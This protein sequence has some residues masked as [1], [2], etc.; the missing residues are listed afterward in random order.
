MINKGHGRRKRSNGCIIKFSKNPNSHI[1]LYYYNA[2]C[3]NCSLIIVYDYSSNV[4]FT[5]W[6]GVCSILR[7]VEILFEKNNK[8]TLKNNI[9]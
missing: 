8:Y 3:H 2:K 7:V 9:K 6:Y 4:L 1:H 5:I